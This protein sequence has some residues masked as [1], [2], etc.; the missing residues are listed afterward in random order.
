MPVKDGI[1]VFDNLFNILLLFTMR[2]LNIEFFL[3]YVYLPV[4]IL[5]S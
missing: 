1:L 4:M 5:I 2:R 3:L